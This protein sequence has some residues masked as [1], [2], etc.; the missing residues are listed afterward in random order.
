[1]GNRKIEIGI[2]VNYG[3]VTSLPQ[4]EVFDPILR[5]WDNLI[6]EYELEY[7]EDGFLNKKIHTVYALLS[8]KEYQEYVEEL[9]FYNSIN[10]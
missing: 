4:L 6:L 1:M 2:Q 7:E 3:G 9:E 10:I 8:D 5:D